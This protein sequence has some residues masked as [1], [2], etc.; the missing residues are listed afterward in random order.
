MNLDKEKF[1]ELTKDMNGK[2]FDSIFNFLASL[3]EDDIPTVKAMK[4]SHEVVDL[5]GE[6][7]DKI[8]N[9][10]EKDVLEEKS[11]KYTN[12]LTECLSLIK[13]FKEEEL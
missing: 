9:I 12:V 8:T 11:K 7:L 2:E 5:I 1:E 3:V 4:L 10:K 6:I 13:A